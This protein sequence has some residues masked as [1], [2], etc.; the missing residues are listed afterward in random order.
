[1]NACSSTGTHNVLS[2]QCLPLLPGATQQEGQLGQ[3]QTAQVFSTALAPD[4]DP[5]AVVTR[6]AVHHPASKVR[7]IVMAVLARLEECSE[8]EVPKK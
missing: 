2:L 7:C 5:P 4:C 3:E 6:S 8:V 1:M